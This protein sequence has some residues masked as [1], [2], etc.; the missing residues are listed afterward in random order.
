MTEIQAAI[1]RSMLSAVRRVVCD[2]SWDEER[3][4]HR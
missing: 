4:I 3:V 2:S 1:M